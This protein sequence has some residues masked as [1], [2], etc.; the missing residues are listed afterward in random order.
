MTGDLTRTDVEP[1][2]K[3]PK[4]A[5]PKWRRPMRQTSEK[6]AE[7]FDFEAM[8]RRKVWDRD[9]G[10][11][12]DGEVDTP[13]AGRPTVH[14]RRK[15]GQGG[16][17][18]MENLVAMCWFHNVEDIEGRPEFYRERFPWLVVTEE[19]AEWESLGRRSERIGGGA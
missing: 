7:A 17:W 14:H 2:L 9:G 6:K 8:Q 13:C 18:S 1:I 4:K 5:K 19:D 16:S 15:A 11:V 12:L 3:A 10:C